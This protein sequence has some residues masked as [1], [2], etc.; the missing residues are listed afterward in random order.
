MR[1]LLRVMYAK[2]VVDLGSAELEKSIVSAK[3]A[4]EHWHPVVLSVTLL[5]IGIVL[6][7]CMAAVAK[8][9]VERYP[10]QQISLARNVFG[11]LPTVSILLWDGRRRN[12]FTALRLQQ[13]PL[14]LSRGLMVAVAQL[15]LYHSFRELE[16]ATAVVLAYCGPLFI[17][18]LAYR[19]LEN[20]LE[21]GAG[22]R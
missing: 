6:L 21:S 22:A 4:M 20:G 15:A 8:H 18:V 17:S 13:W 11:L 1:I 2:S 9:L 19:G 16:L 14:A 5:L 10:A 3:E 7:D 12:I